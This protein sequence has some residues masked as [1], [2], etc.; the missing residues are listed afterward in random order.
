[1]Q[2]INNNKETDYSDMTDEEID[3]AINEKI[4]NMNLSKLSEMNERSRMEYYVS[5]F[6][7]AIEAE[8]YEAAYQMLYSDFKDKYF[9]SI[10]DFESYAKGK[11]PSMISLDYTNIERNGDIYVMWVTIANPL[12]GKNSGSEMNFVLREYG[13]NDFALSFSVN[14][15]EEE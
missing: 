9:P 8:N 10:S 6:I 13:L 14:K 4:D 12:A 11:F 1:M 7:S 15:V 5:E 3:A 2:V